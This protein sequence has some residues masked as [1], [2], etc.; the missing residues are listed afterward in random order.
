MPAAIC[1][2][3]YLR[4]EPN[5]RTALKLG[6]LGVAG[7]TLPNLLRAEKD[8]KPAKRNA[9]ADRPASVRPVVEAL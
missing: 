8:R 1:C 6:G 7:L 9:T 4:N 3:G 5:R 2:P